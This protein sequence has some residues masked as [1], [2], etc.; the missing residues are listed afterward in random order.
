MIVERR[1]RIR[2][3]KPDEIDW[4]ADFNFCESYDWEE[5]PANDNE[6]T[7]WPIL[8]MFALFTGFSAY[9]VGSYFFG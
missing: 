4:V 8:L 9:A 3:T 6:I 1:K 7:P 5:E 2:I